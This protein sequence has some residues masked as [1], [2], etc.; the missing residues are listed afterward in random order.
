MTSAGEAAAQGPG[1]ALEPAEASVEASDE[2]EIP[3]SLFARFESFVFLGRGGMGAVYRARD[4]RLGR[5]VAVKLLFGAD[6]EKGAACCAR[7]D[8]R[9]ASSTRTPAKSTRPASPIMCASSSWSSSTARRSTP[10][11]AG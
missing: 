11:R 2:V 9:R 10:R 4:F 6:P 1:F 5:D 8:R 3:P 7:R